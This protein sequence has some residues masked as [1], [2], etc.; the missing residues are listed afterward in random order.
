[1][2]AI[3]R[4]HEPF[5]VAFSTYQQ[6]CKY[7]DELFV[8][9]GTW[10]AYGVLDGHGSQSAAE[11]SKER[12]LIELTSR[13]PLEAPPEP[14]DVH[15]FAGYASCVRKALASAFVAVDE[16]FRD[17]QRKGGTTATVAVQTGRLLTVGNVGDSTCLLDSGAEVLTLSTTD[18]LDD[19]P[20]EAQ[21]VEAAGS[22]AARL[23]FDLTGPARVGEEGCGPL[24]M[25]PGNT[26]CTPAQ[27]R[28]PVIPFAL[29]PLMPGLPC[30]PPQNGHAARAA[31]ACASWLLLRA[32]C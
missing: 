27:Q 18:R 20:L 9:V 2:T 10:S 24:R 23:T 15:R 5:Q 13:M 22:R 6:Q 3:C 17:G 11:F 19:N 14:A 31:A 8:S 7:Q 25:W 29:M 32:A 1:M 26:T 4:P 28:T 12:L 30:L 16:A 21:R